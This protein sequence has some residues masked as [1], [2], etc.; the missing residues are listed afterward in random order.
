MNVIAIPLIKSKRLLVRGSEPP[1]INHDWSQYSINTWQWWCE[2]NSVSLEIITESNGYL[3]D[4]AYTF[5]RWGAIPDLF[6]KYGSNAK[7]ALVDADTMI[8]WNTPNF[9]SLCPL[10]S[11]SLVP[12]EKIKINI[13]LRTIKNYQNL[14]PAVQLPLEKYYQMGIQVFTTSQLN[15]IKDLENFVNENK[16]QLLEIQTKS[17][18]GTDQ[19]PVNY[20]LFKNNY[21]IHELSWQ[22]N[23]TRPFN[24][25]KSVEDIYTDSSYKFIE[26]AY[27]WHF[28][29]AYP[30]RSQIMA[31]T[32]KRVSSFYK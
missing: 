22:Y 18:V 29:R 25:F 11:I 17:N 31:E 2:K 4:M 8:K 9:F 12:R 10:D 6:K 27:I 13:P 32:W 7:I 26:E 30:Y 16:E 14:F 23:Y 28:V 24:D 15:F 20:L 5:Q 1:R 3:E 21:K 19:G